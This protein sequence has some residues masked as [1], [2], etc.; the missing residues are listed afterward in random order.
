VTLP[1]LIHNATQGKIMI[2]LLGEIGW[3]AVMSRSHFG[4]LL[5]GQIHYAGPN[6]R[7]GFF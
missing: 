1:E 6:Y 3:I 5:L 4:G 7:L 2:F